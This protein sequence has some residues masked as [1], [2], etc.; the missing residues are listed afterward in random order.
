MYNVAM[1]LD[2]AQLYKLLGERIRH[3]RE[4]YGIS[5][6][7]LARASELTRTSITNV[8]KGRQKLPIHAL[9]RVCEALGVELST[10]LPQH[11]EVAEVKVARVDIAELAKALPPL[12]ADW[13]VELQRE[14]QAN[15]EAASEQDES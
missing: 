14:L 6:A 10:L 15:T 8:E 1:A 7:E 12:A 9:Y 3:L 5:Q 13:V 11:S 4:E 2:E